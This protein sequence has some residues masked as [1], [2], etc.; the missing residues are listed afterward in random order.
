MYC[1]RS[2][3]PLITNAGAGCTCCY[4]RL[5]S[6]G[7]DFGAC[8]PPV[9]PA[10]TA[11]LAALLSMQAILKTRAT[12]TTLLAPL[13]QVRIADGCGVLSIPCRARSHPEPGY[14]S[15][16]WHE[17]RRASQRLPTMSFSSVTVGGGQ[18]VSSPCRGPRAH[19]F[20]VER[21]LAQQC[22]AS[23]SALNAFCSGSR[24][25]YIGRA[26]AGPEGYSQS[27]LG[28]YCRHAPHLVPHLCD[29]HSGWLLTPR[30]R[31]GGQ[32]LH[33]FTA[34]IQCRMLHVSERLDLRLEVIRDPCYL[35][36]SSCL[37]NQGQSF[38]CELREQSEQLLSH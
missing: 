13:A 22:S 17:P 33:M 16:H 14:I 7:H 9:G 11:S 5:P 1:H 21:R 15:A 12:N 35:W 29:T 38:Q 23:A 30:T 10:R 3:T 18:L 4:V 20:Q 26:Q 8:K 27:P 37:P 32:R 25:P 19:L 28:G 2:S 34:L 24:V 36:P 6:L 31:E